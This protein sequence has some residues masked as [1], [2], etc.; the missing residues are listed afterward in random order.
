MAFTE[1]PNYCELNPLVFVIINV[2]RTAV[3]D[4]IRLRDAVLKAQI[5][6][7]CSLRGVNLIHS[8]SE[9]RIETTDTG[10]PSN[11]GA[12]IQEMQHNRKDH[13]VYWCCIALY[14]HLCL[15]GGDIWKLCQ[16]TF[17][18]ALTDESLAKDSKG[19]TFFPHFIFRVFTS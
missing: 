16:L 12:E 6:P 10:I 8:S 11:Y 17:Y 9:K 4:S 14:C 13:T 3:K 5:N 2:H 19:P 1:H 7:W 18:R 15:R